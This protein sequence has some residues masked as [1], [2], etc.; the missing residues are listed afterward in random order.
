MRMPV[1]LRLGRNRFRMAP[2]SPE[3]PSSG[4]R[5]LWGRADLPAVTFGAQDFPALVS[6]FPR[7]MGPSPGTEGGAVLG[8]LR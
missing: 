8:V 2:G 5:L 3:P 4:P 1:S 6:P 7:K